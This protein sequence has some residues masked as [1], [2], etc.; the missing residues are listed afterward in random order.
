MSGN[1][2]IEMADHLTQFVSITRSDSDRKKETFFK[3]DYK[4][5]DENQFIDD[6]SIQNWQNSNDANTSF[7]DVL[8]RLEGCIN[9]HLPK[10]KMN[11]KE[12]NWTKKLMIKCYYQSHY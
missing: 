5:W 6:L 9:R 11:K 2:L 12:I 3:R 7:N 8:Y 4:N 10:K 1:I